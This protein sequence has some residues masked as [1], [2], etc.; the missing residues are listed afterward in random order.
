MGSIIKVESVGNK[1]H[2]VTD[3]ENYSNSLN[4]THSDHGGSGSAS[5]GWLF[6][7]DVS[8]RLVDD[9]QK[10]WTTSGKSL[11]EQARSNYF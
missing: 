2:L 9:K 1:S 5:V 4:K 8:A 10:E 3:K 11:N 6:R 7:A